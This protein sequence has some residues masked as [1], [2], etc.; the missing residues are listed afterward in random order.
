MRL[1]LALLPRGGQVVYGGNA[2]VNTK[3]VANVL[4]VM[5]AAVGAAML[6]PGAYSAAVG[7]GLWL[8]F[9]L[10]ALA[11]LIVGSALFLPTRQRQ[12]FVW[13]QDVFLM[14]VLGWF[15]VAIVG[16]T[17][18]VLSGNM[19]Y[20]DAVFNSVAGFT[21]TGAATV[22]PN[23]LAPSL[24]LWRS[25]TQW[26]GGIG[27][28]LLFVAV[29]PLV[30]LGAAR[31]I[32]AELADPI[33]ERMTP[34][35]RDTA[36]VLTYIYVGLTFGGMIALYIA[37]MGIFD[38][39]NHSLTTVATGGYSTRSDSIAAFDSW[40]VEL[41]VVAGMVLSGTNFTLYFY[42]SQGHLARVFRNRE[43]RTYLGVIASGTVLLTV[44]LY[45]FEYHDSLWFAFREALFQSAS[46]TTGTA[47]AT[48]D[49]NAWDPLSQFYLMLAMAIGGC[50]GST[51]GGIK[52]VRIFLLVAHSMQDLVR[53]VHPRIVLPLKFG[54]QVIPE[55]TRV[56]VLAFFFVYVASLVVGTV[57][58][59]AHQIPLDAAFGSV[60][61]CL[62]ITGIAL[63]QVGEPGFYAALPAT[64][65]AI[66]TVF[67]LMGRL[68]I[69]TVLVLLTPSFWR[70]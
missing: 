62:N 5:V 1:T 12:P 7:D 63:G 42:A 3:L 43:L 2:L 52:Q 57:L 49:W 32:S 39:V 58:M 30:G 18:F 40:T 54:D 24:L 28:V 35:I 16:G 8:A 65:K 29:A 70:G 38:A 9:V 31:L 36:K 23:E 15:A 6:I 56:A 37:G 17:P 27:I 68:E 20:V 44:S 64:A 26:L 50:A 21:T 19:G 47:F 67:M 60:F 22:E 46:L 13:L 4:C 41:A 14:V 48:A 10:P 11:A 59:T 25:L 55:R 61:A 51:S 69:L 53:M 45:A 33:P 34:R 66:L